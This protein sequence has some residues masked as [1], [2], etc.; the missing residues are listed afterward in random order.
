MNSYSYLLQKR[1]EPSY[2]LYSSLNK[3]KMKL[4]QRAKKWTCCIKLTSCWITSSHRWRRVPFPLS[5]CL[6]YMDCV[7]KFWYEAIF[8]WNLHVVE[9][10]IATSVITGKRIKERNEGHLN[11]ETHHERDKL[12]KHNL[13]MGSDNNNCSVPSGQQKLGEGEY[14]IWKKK[15]PYPNK[16][17]PGITNINEGICN[18]SIPSSQ[19][20]YTKLCALPKAFHKW[21]AKGKIAIWIKLASWVTGLN[22]LQILMKF[23]IG[24]HSSYGTAK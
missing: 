2:T 19:S 14:K 7:I 5:S 13:E 3:T 16:Q 17:K 18:K 22:C 20:A 10:T 11:Q 15:L 24:H 4:L 8:C 9:K 1:V 21:N 12:R 6:S 23:C